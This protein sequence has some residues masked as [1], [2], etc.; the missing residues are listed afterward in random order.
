[1]QAVQVMS[2]LAQ[3]TRL[4]IYKLLVEHLPQGVAASDIADAVGMSRNGTSPHL[5]IL[6]AAKLVSARKG[7]AGDLQGGDA[8]GG[9]P[10]AIPIAA[11]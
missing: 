3:Q 6:S 2:A 9:G 5:A 10:R 11:R 7:G 8:G 1:M 4:D